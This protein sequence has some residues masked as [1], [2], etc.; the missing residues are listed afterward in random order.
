MRRLWTIAALVLVLIVV[1][2]VLFVSQVLRHS[3]E[4]P[5][6]HALPQGRTEG[7]RALEVT[8]DKG[9][10][11]WAIEKKVG[12]SVDGVA[13]AELPVGFVQRYP[14]RGMPRELVPKELLMIT[15]TFEGSSFLHISSRFAG[16]VGFLHG[17]TVSGSK[18]PDPG[19]TE[20]LRLRPMIEIESTHANQ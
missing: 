5:S 13:Y 7:L 1:G 9:D 20:Q 6:T 14:A 4:V 15:A 11:I 17:L 18:C 16:K 19:C 8:T 2:V 10:L 3:D 12:G